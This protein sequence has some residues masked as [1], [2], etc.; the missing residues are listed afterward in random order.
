MW[1]VRH[2]EN[3][4][5]LLRELPDLGVDHVL[6]DPPYDEHCQ[7]NQMSGTTLEKVE[8]PFDALSDRAFVKD[9]VRIARRWSLVFCT[10]EDLGRFCDTVGGPRTQGGCW[11]RGGIWYKMNSMGQLSGDRPAAAYEGI[12]VMSS[13]SKLRWNGNGSYAIWKCNG[14]RGEKGRHKNQKPLKLLLTLI[15]KF[16]DPDETIFDP[17]CGSGRVGEAAVLMGRRYI[18]LDNDPEW[19]QKAQE[20]IK[21]V[22]HRYGELKDN[23][24]MKSCSMKEDEG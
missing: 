8:L 23:F 20:R 22:E 11:I 14:T 13:A 18:G 4:F 7:D 2:C 16:T 9:L 15:A 19:V 24:D 21:A 1:S 12:A 6:T 5:A 17:F 3:S 10:V